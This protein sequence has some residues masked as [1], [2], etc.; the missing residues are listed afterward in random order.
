[1]K[2]KHKHKPIPLS[3]WKEFPFTALCEDVL[4][5]VGAI[6]SL[7]K[8]TDPATFDPADI[9]TLEEVIT[10][11]LSLLARFCEQIQFRKI[12]GQDYL[13]FDYTPGVTKIMMPKVKPKAPETPLP[14]AP[15]PN[16]N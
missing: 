2:K 12:D 8:K 1:M 4:K 15:R 14:E 13:G 6:Q 9:R 5:R 7:I 3:R 10:Y 16:L 11:S